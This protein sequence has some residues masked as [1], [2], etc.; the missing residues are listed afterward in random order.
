MGFTGGKACFFNFCVGDCVG[1]QLWAK[2]SHTS[3]AVMPLWSTDPCWYTAYTKMA[4]FENKN[5]HTCHQNLS[6]FW[7]ES[8]NSPKLNLNLF[9][10]LKWIRPWYSWFSFERWSPPISIDCIWTS[11]CQANFVE[12]GSTFSYTLITS[13]SRNTGN[14]WPPIRTRTFRLRSIFKFS[15][16]QS[17]E[18]F[19]NE[20]I[21]TEE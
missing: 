8:E 3:N 1:E 7:Y 17:E 21:R 9:Y 13:G 12:T 4:T 5:L 20:P 14:W 18:S 15:L 16:S 2:F 19:K 11:G 10:L 6:T